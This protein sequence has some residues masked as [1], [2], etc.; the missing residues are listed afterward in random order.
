M[1]FAEVGIFACIL[2][3]KRELLVG[4][5]NGR[6]ELLLRAFH[7]VWNVVAVHP[8]HRCSRFDRYGRG[9]EGE[10]I[11]LDVGLSTSATRC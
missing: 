3:S 1:K 6:G 9:I 7:V 5:E 11:D 10:V 2:K 8:R 4:I